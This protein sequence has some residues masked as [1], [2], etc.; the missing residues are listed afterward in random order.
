[1]KPMAKMM[2]L[3]RKGSFVFTAAEIAI[4]SFVAVTVIGIFYSEFLTLVSYVKDWFPV[5]FTEKALVVMVLVI[6]YLATRLSLIGR[7]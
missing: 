4:F 6:T 5:L 7:L 2:P 3:Q 1:M